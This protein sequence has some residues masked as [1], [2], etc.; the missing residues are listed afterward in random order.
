MGLQPNLFDEIGSDYS[1][2]EG[3]YLYIRE[4]TEFGAVDEKNVGMEEGRMS[5]LNVW[6][7]T[8]EEMG[9]M[10]PKVLKPEDL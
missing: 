6:I 10:I 7:I 2:F 5:R 1:S 3:S 9:K 8:D 4:I